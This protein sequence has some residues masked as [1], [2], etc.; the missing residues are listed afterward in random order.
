M[1]RPASTLRFFTF[2]VAISVAG[3]ASGIS[4]LLGG[5]ECTESC[6]ADDAEGKCAPLCDECIC[7]VH[8]RSA[9]PP[10]WVTT[11]ALASGVFQAS[12]APLLLGDPAPRRI[13]HVPK[14]SL[15]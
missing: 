11:P 13:D 2:L 5:Q 4:A 10:V 15:V 3:Q 7:C 1:R 14:P 6:P 12:G 8:P 9:T